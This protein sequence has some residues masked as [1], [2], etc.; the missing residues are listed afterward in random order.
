MPIVGA[1][2]C[3]HIRHVYYNV[4][5]NVNC[6]FC[7]PSFSLIRYYYKNGLCH[8][9]ASRLCYT[10]YSIFLV[11]CF[12]LYLVFAVFSSKYLH[13]LGTALL[14]FLTLSK[15]RSLSFYFVLICVRRIVKALCVVN[16][17]F[18]YS[19]IIST[20]HHLLIF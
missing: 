2:T 3:F 11:L 13:R 7:V 8:S 10:H 17:F 6:I 4:R 15:T 18:L 20:G 16:M 1:L 19:I 12:S 5:L 14:F 9:F